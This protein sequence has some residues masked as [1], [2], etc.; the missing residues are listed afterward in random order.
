[1]VAFF[2]IP[3][4]LLFKGL[5]YFVLFDIIN[6]QGDIKVAKLLD[7]ETESKYMFPILVRDGGFPERTAFAAVS[8]LTLYIQ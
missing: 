7:R 4:I 5:T 2:D 3:L 1:M 6:I 8:C